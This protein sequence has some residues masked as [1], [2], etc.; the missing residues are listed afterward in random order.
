MVRKTVIMSDE[1]VKKIDRLIRGGFTHTITGTIEMAIDRMYRE[2]CQ[3]YYKYK[4]E[5]AKQKEDDRVIELLKKAQE[6][7]KAWTV[8]YDDEDD[9]EAEG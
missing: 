9:G 5:A 7:H 3:T 1:T 8:V 6:K 2:D 4:S